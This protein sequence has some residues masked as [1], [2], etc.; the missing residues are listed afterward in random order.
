MSK[1]FSTK[2]LIVYQKPVISSHQN[3][4][5]PVKSISWIKKHTSKFYLNKK[6]L[7]KTNV[8]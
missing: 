7:E 3:R 1:S 8:S 6:T 5:L 4:S 2:K